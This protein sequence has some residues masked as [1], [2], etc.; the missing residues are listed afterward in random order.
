VAGARIDRA[1]QHVDILEHVS[2]GVQARQVDCR[3]G[4]ESV[5]VRI[6]PWIGGHVISVVQIFNLDHDDRE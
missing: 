5:D 1:K 2:K 3:T 6:N 4:P